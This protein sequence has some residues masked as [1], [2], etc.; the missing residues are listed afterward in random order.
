MEEI[1]ISLKH[2]F[3]SIIKRWRCIISMMVVVALALD[4][5]AVLKS[6]PK[7]RNTEYVDTTTYMTS[8]NQQQREEVELSATTFSVYDEAYE[9][10]MDYVQHSIRMKLDSS[11]VPTYELQY[12]VLVKGQENSKDDTSIDSSLA[13]D[14]LQ[15]YIGKLSNQSVYN[16]IN[17]ATGWKS[18]SSYVKELIGVNVDKAASITANRDKA[19]STV[20]IT[21]VA[22]DK[23]SAE[24]MAEVIKSVM[25]ES[26]E[27]FK[28]VYGD[29]DLILQ[30]ENYYVE[31]S[32]VIMSEQ[33]ARLA[34]VTTAKAQLEAF[35]V[36]FKG[37]QLEYYNALVN[38]AFLDAKA[39]EQVENEAAVI[40]DEQSSSDISYIN[41][42]YIVIGL[43]VG[44][45]LS[46]FWLA[47]VYI[48]GK[49][50]RTKDDM[51]DVFGISL[52]GNIRMV[53]TKKKLCRG[54]DKLVDKMFYGKGPQFTEDERLAMICAGI[55][56][57]AEKGDMKTVFVTGSCNDSGTERIK[58]AIF[59]SLRDAEVEIKLGGSMVY[60]PESLETMSSSGGVVLV[61]RTGYSL[62]EDILREKELCEKYEIPVI[63][64]VVLE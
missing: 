22:L 3:Y 29:F 64:G 20:T 40:E 18:S 55:R 44:L 53:A 25:E 43:A 27:G 35:E 11:A 61:E 41:I 13:V 15:A 45:F 2:M 46:V 54:I 56:I 37:E 7:E 16:Q 4:V 8:L 28:E 59:T 12:Y 30:N 62:Y 9:S 24:A 5:F 26:T 63:G 33:Q 60:D 21:L 10:A 34:A 32:P 14:I 50:I 38:N 42:K 52:L 49:T 23:A 17:Q 1:E 39:K 58:D 51:S 48:V 19:S 6:I 57:S 36:D 47:F 31:A